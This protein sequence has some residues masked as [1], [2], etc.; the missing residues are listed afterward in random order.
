MLGYVEL[1]FSVRGEIRL[2]LAALG[3]ASRGRASRTISIRT[4]T[5]YVPK[6]QA[7]FFLMRRNAHGGTP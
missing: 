7:T 1:S 5:M 2:G 3:W 6:G 4:L